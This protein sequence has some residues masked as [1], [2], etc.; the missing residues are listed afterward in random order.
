VHSK[1]NSITPRHVAL[2]SAMVILLT[3]H[4]QH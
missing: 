3:H 2:F 4:T 1:N